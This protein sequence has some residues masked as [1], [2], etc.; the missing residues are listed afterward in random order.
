[1]GYAQLSEGRV[2]RLNLI[3]ELDR[4]IAQ[5][6]PEAAGYGVRIERDYD[7]IFPPLLMQRGHL[8]EILLNLLQ[9]AREALNGHGRVSVT[10]RC[11]ADES[12]EIAI[13]DN[14]P[15]IPADKFESIFEAYYTTKDKGTG[16]GLAIVKHNIELY[17]GTVR[18][19]SGLGIG[20]RFVLWL[21]GKAADSPKPT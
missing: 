13:A 17:G 20:A 3:E 6:F 8:V 19:E 1:M 12:V 21:P 18:V 2:E 14:G 5:V 7:G 15:G 16:L 11:R 10:A 4:A 9:N